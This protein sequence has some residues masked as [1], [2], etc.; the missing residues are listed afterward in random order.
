MEMR[1]DRRTEKSNELT[2]DKKGAVQY[3]QMDREEYMHTNTQMG[4]KE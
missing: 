3:I 2:D 1:T 4:K